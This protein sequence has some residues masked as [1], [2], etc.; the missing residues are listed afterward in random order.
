MTEA[1]PLVKA[2][3]NRDPRAIARAI[4]F[5]E[6]GDRRAEPILTGLDPVLIEKATVIGITGPPGAGKSTLTDKL[7]S[8]YRIQNERIGV[9]AIDP[10]SPISG[11][12]ILGDRIRMMAHALDNDVVMRS[13]ATRGRLGGLCGAAGAATRIMAGS[14]CS[15]IIIETV[16]VGQSEMDIIRL[17][18]ITALV[19]APGLGDDIQAMKAGLLEVA[20]LLVVNKA[21][22]PGAES[23]AMDMETVAREKPPLADNLAR[24]WL[25]AATE[26]R[27]IKEL[28][29]TL[30]RF[31]QLHRQSD[32]HARRRKQA[33]TMEVLDW[34][35]EMLRPGLQNLINR[36]DVLETGDPRLL[37]AKIIK[38]LADNQ[39]VS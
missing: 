5:V 18:D 25:T 23:L 28:R 16:G 27:G 35:L 19:V 29:E 4:S 22:C 12:A 26:D 33:R 38:E 14:G 36:H 34:S 1:E 17:A 10:S 20:D 11:G 31:D 37:A 32:E 8:Q 24:V 9:I 2:I 39:Q 7:I 30:A 21:D 15:T 6:D 3:I 13:M